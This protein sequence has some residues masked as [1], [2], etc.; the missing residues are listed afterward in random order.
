MC[1]GLHRARR[2][3]APTA[4]APRH[5]IL[6]AAHHVSVFRSWISVGTRAK[7][8]G[9]NEG[10]MMVGSRLLGQQTI[11]T[12][13]SCSRS[14]RS[15]HLCTAA[16]SVYLLVRDQVLPDASLLCQR[17]LL[18]GHID[19]AREPCRLFQM[20]GEMR[21]LELG[22]PPMHAC[23]HGAD[24][25]PSVSTEVGNYSYYVL[26]LVASQLHC[27]FSVRSV[28]SLVSVSKQTE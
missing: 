17:Q 28:K 6:G 18:F 4:M 22:A 21:P 14:Q 27:R 7:G 25:A 11:D 23:M 12:M 3:C 8:A 15:H 24:S 10:E 13:T 5:L 20:G 1:G 16:A 19:A 26:W 2:C 9:G